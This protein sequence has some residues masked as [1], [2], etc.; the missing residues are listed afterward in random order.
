[1]GNGFRQQSPLIFDFRGYLSQP[2]EAF[3]QL[4]VF[5]NAAGGQDEEDGDQQAEDSGQGI[6]AMDEPACFADIKIENDQGK[7]DADE[8]DPELK[9]AVLIKKDRD[10]RDADQRD[11]QHQDPDIEAGIQIL[12]ARRL[13]VGRRVSA[14]KRKSDGEKSTYGG[15]EQPEGLHTLEHINRF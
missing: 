2:V 8:H 7:E 11:R 4:L 12:E 5:R 3:D 13:S 15:K 9:L 6:S 14:I 1:M 10:H